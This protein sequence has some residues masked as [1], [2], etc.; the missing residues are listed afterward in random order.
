MNVSSQLK[1]EEFISNGLYLELVVYND[2]VAKPGGEI[3]MIY[4]V[5]LTI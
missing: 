5:E 1:D 2:S 4:F 3:S